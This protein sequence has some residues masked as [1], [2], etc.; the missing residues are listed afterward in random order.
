MTFSEFRD[1]DGRP[2]P[3]RWSMVPLDKQGHETVIEI[4]E[5]LFDPEIP[6]SVFTKRN[7]ERN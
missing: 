7:L 1:V 6:E 3:H 5:I 4:E 2:F